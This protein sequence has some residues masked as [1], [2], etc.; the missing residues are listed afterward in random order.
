MLESSPVV[1]VSELTY[2]PEG[3]VLLD[4]VSAAFRPGGVTVIMG[5]NG[6][7]K[8]LLLRLIA[9]LIQPDAGLVLLKID[10]DRGAARIALVA[11][12]PVLLRRSVYANLDFA[13][14]V[15]G[16]ERSARPAR[17]GNLLALVGLEA[18]AHLML[19]CT[20]CQT[21]PWWASWP[22]F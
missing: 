19:S 3:A 2:A 16:V 8:S 15:Y 10:S 5:P 17:I 22:R 20:S 14:D 18:L 7:G 11:Q 12:R 1:S 6:A 4:A 13:L 9:G 21:L